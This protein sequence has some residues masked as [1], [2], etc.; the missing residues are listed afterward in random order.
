MI[1]AA[2][3]WLEEWPLM[4]NGKVDRRRL[5]IPEETRPDLATEYVAPRTEIEQVVAS[6]WQQVLQ[7]EKVGLHDNFFDLGGHSLRML[8]VNAKLREA[9]NQ[10]ISMVEMFQYP[11][12]DLIARFLS[13]ELG[14]MEQPNEERTS[15]R[16]RLAQQQRQLR[17]AHRAAAE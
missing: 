17:Q 1:P 2:F 6:I 4:T 11:T 16:K 13:R 5:S 12:I 3:V 14:T 15:P 8:Q 10:D 7:V 9:F